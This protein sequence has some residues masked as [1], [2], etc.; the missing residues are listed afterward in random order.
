MC[1]PLLPALVVAESP[2]I[3]VSMLPPALV[4]NAALVPM[5]IVCVCAPALL[6]PYDV[7]LL[8]P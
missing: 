6:I 3:V 7:S 1:A 4:L 5:V 2:F 8:L